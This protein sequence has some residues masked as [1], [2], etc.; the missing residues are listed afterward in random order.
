MKPHKFKSIGYAFG[1]RRYICEACGAQ[2][3]DNDPPHHF[4]SWANVSL[5]CNLAKQQ[6]SKAILAAAIRN[7]IN[8]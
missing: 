2:R 3:I 1:S 6:I 8:E 5:D 4:P 7:K